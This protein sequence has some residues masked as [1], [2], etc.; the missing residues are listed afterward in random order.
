MAQI[1]HITTPHNS[2]NGD[3]LATAMENQNSMNTELYGGKVDKVGGKGLSDTNFSQAE[4][5]KLALLNTAV[6]PQVQADMSVTNPLSLAY[7]ANKPTKTSDFINDGDGAYAFITA[8][9]IPPAA[10]VITVTFQRLTVAQQDFAIPL[11][12]IAKQAFVNG[13]IWYLND[14]NLATEPNTFTQSGATVTF[15]TV[16][17]IGNLIVIYIQ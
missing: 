3:P 8:A 13:A 6:Q 5:D 4:K 9:S 11:G 14:A 10:T 7:V 2:G 12:K 16:R 17:P 1:N 15:K